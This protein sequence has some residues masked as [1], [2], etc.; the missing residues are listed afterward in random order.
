MM[1]QPSAT[2]RYNRGIEMGYILTPLC[3]YLL[4]GY[5]YGYTR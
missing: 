3:G 1:V 5:C 4:K 2:L